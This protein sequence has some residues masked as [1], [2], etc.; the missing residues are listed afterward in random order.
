LAAFQSYNLQPG[1]LLFQNSPALVWGLI[2]SLY[3]GNVILLMLNLPLVGLWVKLLKVPQ[4]LLYAGILVFATIG[5]Y[6]MRQSAFDLVLMFGIGLIGVLMRRYDFPVAP[7][8][9][10]MI[11]G[12]MSE[13]QLRNALSIAQGDWSIFVRRPIALTLLV[14]TV[15]ILFVPM[16]MRRKGVSLSEDD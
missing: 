14:L 9:I 10:G 6:G 4:P 12:P 5:V 8:I 3:I 16:W 2:A 13:K 7:V 11:V 1:P 15:L